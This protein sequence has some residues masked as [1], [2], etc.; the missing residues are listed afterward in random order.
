MIEI[1]ASHVDLASDNVKSFAFLATVMADGTPQV[2]PVWFSFRDG[3]LLI[4][5]AEGRT[6]DRNMRERPNVAVS[7]PDPGNMYRYVQIRG[8][9]VEITRE[10]AVDHINWLSQKYLGKPYNLPEGQ[11]RVIY[12]V[13]PDV[14]T[15]NG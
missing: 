4:N 5:S 9:I 14:V 11:T 3:Y 8:R 13:E 6:K 1:P 7:I 2:T 10:G 15:V 12:R